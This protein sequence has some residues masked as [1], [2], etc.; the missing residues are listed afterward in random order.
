MC[1]CVLLYICNFLVNVSQRQNK[2]EISSTCAHTTNAIADLICTILSYISDD[3][4]CSLT[5]ICCYYDHKKLHIEKISGFQIYTWRLWWKMMN[6]SRVK[7]FFVRLK[8]WLPH[9]ALNKGANSVT[10]RNDNI[11]IPLFGEHEIFSKPFI[12]SETWIIS[13]CKK[14]TKKFPLNC[15]PIK[16]FKF[17]KH[18]IKLQRFKNFSPYTRKAI[19][20]SFERKL[21]DVTP[22]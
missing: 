14:I 13:S 5:F 11:S 22:Q 7:L 17:E 4:E 12:S 20:I 9:K 1:V 18:L 8:E 6:K 19:R 16:I 3:D 10:V 15:F 2:R 21:N